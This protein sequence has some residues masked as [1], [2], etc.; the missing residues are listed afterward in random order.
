MKKILLLILAALLL[1]SGCAGPAAQPTQ[2]PAEASAPATAPQTT[3]P[4][5]E[6]TPEPK[7]EPEGVYKTGSMKLEYANQ[8]SVDH[9]S[10]GSALLTIGEDRF[11]IL[12][13][14]IA[15]PGFET[16][17]VIIRRNI[18]LLVMLCLHRK[19]KRFHRK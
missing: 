10:D 11:L 4:A 5:A 19:D 6:I 3:A 7:E 16:D 9:Y 12:P 13:E 17:A 1:F 14:G 2:A 18:R 8:F 15:E